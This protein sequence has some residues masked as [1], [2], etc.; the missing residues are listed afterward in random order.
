MKFLKSYWIYIVAAFITLFGIIT[1]WY[2]FIFFA[3]P[4]ALFRSK[5]LNE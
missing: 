4:F 3:I 1:G 5:D 2:L